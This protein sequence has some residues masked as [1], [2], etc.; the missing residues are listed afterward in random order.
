MQAWV[1]NEMDG[2]DL[3]DSRLNDRCVAII[4]ALGSKPSLSIPAACNGWA[5]TQATYRFFAN[6]SVTP[7]AIMKPHRDAT[8]KRMSQESVV[9]LAQDTTVLNLTRPSEQIAGAG[10]LSDE[11][12]H[13]MF[14]HTGLAVNADGIPLGVCFSQFWVRDWETFL[15]NKQLTKSQKAVAKRKVPYAE[16]ESYRWLEGYMHGCEAARKCPD[17]QIIVVSD[18]EA[19]IAD[20]FTYANEI[21]ANQERSADWITRAF[22]DRALVDCAEHHKLWQ[23]CQS[24]PVL[25]TIEIEVSENKPQSG[26]KTKRNQARQAR[27]TQVEVRAVAVTVNGQPRVE[28]KLAPQTV[29]VVYMRELNPPEGEKPIEWLLLTSLDISTVENVL[30]VIRYYVLRWKVEIY[31]RVLKVGCGVEELQFERIER[32]QR[33]LAVYMV[34]AWRVFHLMMM[35]RTCPEISCESVLAPE[36]WKALYAIASKQAVP[37]TAPTLGEALILIAKLGGYLARKGDGPPGPQ[38]TWIGLQRLRDFALAW[39]AFG[40]DARARGPTCV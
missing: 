35:G 32:Y 9:V 24:A 7:E 3:G 10:P 1:E 22:Q 15:A 31:F 12:N 19:D 16:K 21:R 17:T 29:N 20:C 14:N 8:L 40:P 11:H 6:D 4:S 18:S 2:L 13:G 30:L 27:T 28:G 5:E 26:D 38:S 34:V 36:E 39:N 33:C 25:T 37:E 23:A